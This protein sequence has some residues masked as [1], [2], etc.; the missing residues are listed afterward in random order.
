MALG[1]YADH[2]A[3]IDLSSGSVNYEGINEQDAR[4]YIGARGLGVKYLFDNGPSVDALSPDNMLA[5][6]NGPLTGSEATMS[7]RL[8]FVTKSPLTGT[9]TDSHMGGWSAARLR[10]AGFDALL[11]KGKAASPVYAYIEKGTVELRPADEIWGKGVHETMRFFKDRYGDD[12]SVM[13]IGQA[14]ENG[15]LFASIINENDRAAGRG[16]TGAVAGSKNLKAIVV[17]ADNSTMPKAADREKWKTAHQRALKTI[18]DSE[19]LGP[20]TGGLSLYGTNVLTNVVNALGGMGTRNSQTTTYASAEKL[21]GET[22]RETILV[23]EPTCHACPV[24]CKKEVEIK[25][26]PYKGLRMES[27]EYEPAWSL[28]A[29]CDNDDTGVVAKVIDQCNDYGMDAIEIGTVLSMLMEATER[30][31]VSGSGLAWGDGAGMVQTAERIAMREGIGDTLANGTAQAAES[32]GHPEIAMTVKGQAVA[33]Y[34]PRAVKGEGIGYATSNRGA[35]HLRGYTPASE[36]LGIPVKTDPLAWEGKGELLKIFQDL[37]AFSDSLDLCK[38]SAFS[39]GAEEYAAQYE[40]IVGI[41]MSEDEVMRTGERIYN[42]ERYF[43]NQLGFDGKD[44]SLP[45]RFLKEP[46]TGAAA[47]SVCELDEMK[48]EYYAARGWDDGVVPEAKLRELQIIG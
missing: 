42:L 34:D 5:L 2:V 36:L 38:F 40:A 4:L 10:W 33:A 27:F 19:V 32:F 37:H 46:G 26:G 14:G 43:N 45:E 12:L 31:Y 22:V 21:S 1:G 23:S 20:K 7:G 15:V 29:N 48:A 3:R 28:G 44:D 8:A 39:E 25:D 18:M 17:K 30:E 11:F 16:G 24:A 41:P 9:V 13:A 6:V 47:G 35:C